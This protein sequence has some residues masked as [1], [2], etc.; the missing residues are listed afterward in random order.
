MLQEIKTPVKF[1]RWREAPAADED[2][3]SYAAAMVALPVALGFLGAWVDGLLN[4]RPLMILIF[5]GFGVVSAF[6]SAFYR[7]ESRIASHDAN[8]PWSRK[9]SR[10]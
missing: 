1:T 3:L 6:V 8:K 9:T 10:S 5:A 4:T 2:A 7:Y